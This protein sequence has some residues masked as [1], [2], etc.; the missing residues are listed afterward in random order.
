MKQKG[1]ANTILMAI[2]VVLLGALVYVAFVKKSEP[3]VKQQSPGQTTTPTLKDETADW[4]TYRNEKYGF[5]VKYPQDWFSRDCNST[6]VGFSYSQSKLPLCNTDQK[7][8]HIEIFVREKDVIGIE[9]YIKDTQNYLGNSLKTTLTVNG[10]I[11]ATKI[12]G[13]V[14]AHEGPGPDGGTQTIQVLFSDNNNIYQVFY[15][16][17]D[18]KDYSQF[19]DQILSTFKFTN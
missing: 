14:K 12:T 4:Q 3:T 15:Y 16:G 10:N 6:F 1:F 5:T 19:F 13:L 9:K 7:P 17:L 18:N 11:P 2:I 8:P